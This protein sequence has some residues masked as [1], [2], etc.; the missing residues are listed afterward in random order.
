LSGLELTQQ[1]RTREAQEGRQRMPIIALTASAMPHELAACLECGMDDAMT[2]PFVIDV[3]RQ[4]LERW[5]PPP[6]CS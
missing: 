1:I 4:M 5:C 3:L 6:K 2:K